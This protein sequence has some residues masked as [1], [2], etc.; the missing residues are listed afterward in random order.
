MDDCM[1]TVRNVKEHRSRRN[2]MNPHFTSQG[3]LQRKHVVNEEVEKLASKLM[4]SYEHGQPVDLDQSV[5]QVI[6]GTT[7]F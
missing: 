2:V 3:V 1:A 4:Q 7:L 5:G 6:V